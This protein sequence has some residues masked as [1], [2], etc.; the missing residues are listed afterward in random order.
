MVFKFQPLAA[1][2]GYAPDVYVTS[3]EVPSARPSPAM[4]YLNMIRMDVWLGDLTLILYYTDF[5]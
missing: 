2:E 5:S 3:D 1:A 4:I